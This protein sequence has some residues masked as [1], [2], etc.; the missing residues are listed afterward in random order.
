MISEK[1]L[2]NIDAPITFYISWEM[3]LGWA[4]GVA[5]ATLFCFKILEFILKNY[6]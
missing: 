1:Y 6:L 3:K 2:P 4:F 5:V